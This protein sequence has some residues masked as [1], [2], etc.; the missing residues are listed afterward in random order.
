MDLLIRPEIVQANYGNVF[1]LMIAG[2]I[3]GYLCQS[4]VEMAAQRDRALL[5]AA[6][7]GE[8]A[9]LARAVHDGVLQVLALVQRRGGELGGE[10]ASLGAMA[11]EQETQLRA[12]IRQ[13]DTVGTPTSDATVDLAVELEQLASARVT[14]ATPGEPVPVAGDRGRELLAV[15][16][17]C[18]DNVAAHV[19]PEAPA[20][21]LLE[22]VGTDVVLSVR[23]DGPGIPA[24]R[25]E[26]AAAEGRLGVSESIRGRIA[27]LGGATAL[28]SGEYGT[29]WE[30]TVPR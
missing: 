2:P 9:R 19:G 28:D 14:V 15:V 23:D 25:L 18:L 30:L 13:Q 27:D 29:E 26:S 20:W 11:G 21:V 24:G 4:L 17:A 3:V 6:V 12:L 10:F 1:L 7:A 22:V 16:R 8:R 5:S